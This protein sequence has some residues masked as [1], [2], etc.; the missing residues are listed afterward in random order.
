MS[1]AFHR[2]ARQLQGSERPADTA[3]QE[4]LEDFLARWRH[5]MRGPLNALL[6]AT[7]VLERAP[8]G[9]EA[10]REA[11]HVIARQARTLAWVISERPGEVPHER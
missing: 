2:P 11:R 4:S 3:A 9:S 7:G 5:A 10:A 8:E 6:A 1:F